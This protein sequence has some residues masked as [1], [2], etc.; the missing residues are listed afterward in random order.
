VLGVMQAGRDLDEP[1]HEQA[2]GNGVAGINGV[3][4]VASVAAVDRVAELAPHHLPQLVG[5][6]EVAA[7]EG[8]APGREANV[9]GGRSREGH[10]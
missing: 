1:L 4:G 7:V 3:A 9:E 6:E 10:S 2:I 5:G 8:R